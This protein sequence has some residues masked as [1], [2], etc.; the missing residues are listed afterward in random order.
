MTQQP[1]SLNDAM[2]NLNEVCS[3]H[4]VTL[5]EMGATLVIDFGDHAHPDV[6]RGDLVRAVG[7]HGDV[8]RWFAEGQIRI[9]V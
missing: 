6:L 8:E 9:W 2:A 1:N 3:A 7:G 5:I 4:G